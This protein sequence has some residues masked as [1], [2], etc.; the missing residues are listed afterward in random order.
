MRR[1]IISQLQFCLA[2]LDKVTDML[3]G[4]AD[5]KELVESANKLNSYIKKLSAVNN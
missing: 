3:E 1:E 2:T 5:T 4:V